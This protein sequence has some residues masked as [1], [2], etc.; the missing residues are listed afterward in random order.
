MRPLEILLA[1]GLVII[2][3]TGTEP[4]LGTPAAESCYYHDGHYY[5]YRWNGH[6]YNYH[7]NGHYYRTR[8]RCGGNGHYHWCYG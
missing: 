1:A 7:H 3:W 6:Y 5:R 4:A 8:H 2:S